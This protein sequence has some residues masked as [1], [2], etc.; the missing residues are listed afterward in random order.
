MG[1]EIERKFLLKNENWRGL[2]EGILYRQA[3]LNDGSG[4]TVRVRIIGERGFLAIKGPT[5]NAA[6]QEFEYEI[7]HEEAAEMLDTLAVTPVVEKRRYTIPHDK[8]IWEVDEFIGANQGLI[9]AEIELEDA[10]QSFPLPS[11][12]GEEVTDDPRYYNSNLARHPYTSW[13]EER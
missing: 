3:Y 5:V 8:F 4:P 10:D 11:W 1:K 12:V 9:F 7:P 13:T 2:A 6:R